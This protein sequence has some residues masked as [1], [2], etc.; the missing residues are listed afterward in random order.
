WIAYILA[1][2]AVVLDQ[3]SK[4][5]VVQSVPLASGV[6]LVWPLR[7]THTSNP[8]VSFG[9][10]QGGSA[11]IRWGFV[12]F[13]L[14]VAVALG[15]WARHQPRLMPA[16]GIGLIMGGAIGNALDRARFGF[17]V[18]FI[19]V[20]QLGFF[21]WIFNVADSAISVGVVLLVLDSM[22]RERPA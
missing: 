12:A 17:V 7:V 9:M 14:A 8:G 18:D 16:A 1:L 20:S 2:T 19:D 21:P 3:A 4:N 13:S 15:V 6:S 22:R 5:W 10:L 11:L